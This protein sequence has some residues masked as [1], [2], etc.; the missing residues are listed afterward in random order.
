MVQIKQLS[1]TKR[2]AQALPRW[3]WNG[4]ANITVQEIRQATPICYVYSSHMNWNNGMGY[5]VL[6]SV[7]EGQNVWVA[8]TDIE[9]KKYGVPFCALM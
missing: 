5:A 9:V 4:D 3:S 8:A 2:V 7:R 1:L 6:M